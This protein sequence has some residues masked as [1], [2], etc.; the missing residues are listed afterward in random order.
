[1]GNTCR[2]VVNAVGKKGETYY[3]QLN[4]KKELENW[5]TDHQDKL[6]MDEV[7]IVDKK[8]PPFLKW[9]LNK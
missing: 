9:F 1:M 4:T 6:L 2:F 8:L 3:T 7:K 5:I